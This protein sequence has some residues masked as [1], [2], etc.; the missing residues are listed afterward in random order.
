MQR[1]G[2]GSDSSERLTKSAE[3][4]LEEASR[5]VTG[6]TSLPDET[7]QVGKHETS[8]AL[9]NAAK[10]TLSLVGTIMVA[11][12]V[13]FMI[14]RYLSPAVFGQ[15]NFADVY[16]MGFFVFTSFGIDSYIR[17]EVSTRLEHANDFWAGFW[18]LRLFTA[19]LI[20]GFMAMGLRSMHK[21][22][23][24]WRLVFLF[25]LGQVAFIQ[26][27]TVA[28]L[29]QAASEVNELS[30]MNVLSKLLWGG[31]I[32]VALVYGWPLE[33]IALAFVVSETAKAA[34]LSVVVRRKLHLK[35]HIN[36]QATWVA[37]VAS[38]PYYLNSL[39]HTTYAR[40]NVTMLS[41]M[42]NDSEVGW[43]GAAANIAML[44]GLFLP[45]L[46][47]VVVPMAARTARKDP[48]A[49][50]EIMRGAVRLVLVCGTFLSLII[51]LHAQTIV[52]HAFGGKGYA[53]S[54]ISLGMIAPMFVL[55]YLATLGAMHLIQLD[56]IW[57]MIKVSAAALII[58]PLLNAPLILYGFS[59]GPGWAGGLSALASICTE[60]ANAFIT[61]YI[62][63]AAAVDGR[64][65]RVVFKTLAICGM[66]AVVHVMLPSWQ[67]WRVPLETVLYF[68]AA[69]ASGALPYGEIKETVQ[70][71]LAFRRGRA[72]AAP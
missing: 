22:A 34:Y 39:C 18:L 46:Q 53:E 54:A 44:S 48:E 33:S 59:I 15:L 10:L 27:L 55:T 23:L 14:P 20:C 45:I 41:G 32:W 60:G 5:M 9:I 21:G 52:D 17:K 38:F 70:N 57:T 16:A 49:M 42:T 67:A 13:R 66:V 40:L 7:T 26:N 71:A 65:W 28:S 2:F 64:L 63:G 69:L 43:Y 12:V 19:V 56:R 29:L 58:N 1:Q 68:G 37:L 30:Y 47:A 35:W 4:A 3:N 24:E 51:M 50:N 6:E 11:L 8:L 36:T 62:L 25:A 61:F 31:G 72:Q